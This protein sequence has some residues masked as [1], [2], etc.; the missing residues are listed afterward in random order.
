MNANNA[1]VLLALASWAGVMMIPHAAHGQQVV[2]DPKQYAYQAE[3]LSKAQQAIQTATKQ[4]ETMRDA[5]DVAKHTYQMA[6]NQYKELIA[7]GEQ[8]EGTYNMATGLVDDLKE[9]REKFNVMVETKGGF[10]GDTF[11]DVWDNTSQH[12]IEAFP[13]AGSGEYDRMAASAAR[14]KQRQTY[15]RDSLRQAELALSESGERLETINS[16]SQ[17]IDSAENLKAAQDL[18]NRLLVEQLRLA[19]RMDDTLSRLER[20]QSAQHYRGYVPPDDEGEDDN[21]RQSPQE[22]INQGQE[23]EWAHERLADDYGLDS[24]DSGNDIADRILRHY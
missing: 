24:D 7:I 16:L 23:P 21:Q 4:L 5:M 13:E 6:S 3:Q 12:V 9:T 22:R 10:E 17:N 18:N 19:R 1:A 8:M 15:Y 2:T 11:E 20:L 14:E